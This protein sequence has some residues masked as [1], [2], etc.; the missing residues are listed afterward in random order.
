V[1]GDGY[2]MM[3]WITRDALF[4]II[5][6]VMKTESKTG[7]GDGVGPKPVS[8]RQFTQAV[9]KALYRPALL[10]ILALSSKL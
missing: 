9:S 7:T 2:H 8:K 4:G 10:A 3:S 5:R 6:L 1:F